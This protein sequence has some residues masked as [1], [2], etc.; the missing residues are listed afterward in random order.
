MDAQ[1]RALLAL[2]AYAHHYEGGLDAFLVDLEATAGLSVMA[3]WN[4]D[5]KKSYLIGNLSRWPHAEVLTRESLRAINQVR[6]T[7]GLPIVTRDKLGS[8]HLRVAF[9]DEQKTPYGT[10]LSGSSGNRMVPAS[11]MRAQ[12]QAGLKLLHRLTAP[13]RKDD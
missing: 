3:Q 13:E 11:R 12:T 7:A 5:A 4:A 9:G 10:K 6:K 8:L 2:L 1:E